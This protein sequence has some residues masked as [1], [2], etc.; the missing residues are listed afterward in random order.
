MSSEFIQI[1]I[2]GSDRV[3]LARKVLK[4]AFKLRRHKHTAETTQS[5]TNTFRAEFCSGI[6]YC[7]IVNCKRLQSSRA[8]VCC[9]LVLAGVIIPPFFTFISSSDSRALNNVIWIWQMWNRMRY[10][11]WKIRLKD[12]SD[13]DRRKLIFIFKQL[14]S[15]PHSSFLRQIENRPRCNRISIRQRAS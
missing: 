3:T 7:E 5:Q 4:S 6:H 8:Q 1:L 2:V 15:V 11:R 12:A 9:C 14:N 10:F 13:D